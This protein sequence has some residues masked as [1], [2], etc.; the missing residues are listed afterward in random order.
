[1]NDNFRTIKDFRHYL[2]TRLHHLYPASEINSIA[3]L[4]IMTLFNLNRLQQMMKP[5]YEISP[6]HRRELL[7][8]CNNLEK[9]MPVQYVLGETFFYNCRI[10]VNPATLIPR[11]E[12]EELVDLILK[13]NPGFKG[14]I[15]DI[16]TGPGT[17]AIALAKHLPYASITAIDISDKALETARE[18][19]KLNNVKVNFFKADILKAGPEYFPEKFNILV[20]NPPYVPVSEKKNLHINVRE[21]EPETALFVPDDNPLIYYRA[22]LEKKNF[23]LAPEGKIYFEIHEKMGK[24]LNTLMISY[25]I[26]ETRIIKDLN[27]KERFITGK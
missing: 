27:G 6:T 19:A 24:A 13:E 26:K 15:I 9:G 17:I 20:S 23:L 12:T 25:G 4:I 5:E 18:N 8:I 2:H 16:G 10:K 21:F 3:D 7:E 1:M 11:Q 14:K 22:I